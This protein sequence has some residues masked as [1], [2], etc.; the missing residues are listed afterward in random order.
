[1]SAAPAVFEVVTLLSVALGSVVVQAVAQG[2][3]TA[4]DALHVHL[5][6]GWFLTGLLAFY[7]PQDAALRYGLA[8]C[9]ITTTGKVIAFFFARQ[10]R[11]PPGRPPPLSGGGPP[12]LGPPPLG[13]GGGHIGEP[14]KPH[15]S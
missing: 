12:P 1:M 15:L 4:E 3:I 8:M 6:L 13:Y 5:T 7:V 11:G 2:R 9:S 10:P 14:S